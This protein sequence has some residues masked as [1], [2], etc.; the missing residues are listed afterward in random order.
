MRVPYWLKLPSLLFLWV[1]SGITSQPWLNWG[2][3]SPD[4]DSMQLLLFELK[5]HAPYIKLA[6][7]FVV[8]L[9]NVFS[10]M[11]CC[12]TTRLPVATPH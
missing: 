4:L 9:H 1:L 8:A 5:L 2:P 6:T 7:E 12:R 11:V 10:E 3:G